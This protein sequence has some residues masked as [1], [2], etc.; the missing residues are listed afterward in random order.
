MIGLPHTAVRC[1]SYKD[2]KAVHRGIL[3]GTVVVAVLM[4][5]MR[6]AHSAA[7]C[8]RISRSPIR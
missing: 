2:S 7:R 1:I 5:G 6:P 3:L 8:C 4:F